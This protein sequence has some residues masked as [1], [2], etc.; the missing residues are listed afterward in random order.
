MAIRD[1]MPLA[2]RSREYDKTDEVKD[3]FKERREQ[4]MVTRLH[5]E[6][7]KDSPVKVSAEEVDAY[8]ADN[9][10]K[11]RVPERRRGLGVICASEADALAAQLTVQNGAQWADMVQEYCIDQGL[12]AQNGDLGQ[13][14]PASAGPL[15]ELVFRVARVGD[16]SFPTELPDGR[17]GVVKLTEVLEEEVHPL[18]EL[19]ARIGEIIKAEKDE[20]YFRERMD[21]W[22]AEMAIERYPDKL[23]KAVFDPKPSSQSISVSGGGA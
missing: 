20:V 22:K 10:E 11:F 16:I 3:E 4:A 9:P 1:L 6:I 18:S 12:K 19:R 17:W 14:S 15:G 2:A 23:M 13:I 7:V 21:A 8:Y 5:N